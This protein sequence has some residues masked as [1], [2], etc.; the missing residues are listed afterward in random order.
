M[1]QENDVL[2]LMKKMVE[3]RK[4]SELATTE[5]LCDMVYQCIEDNVPIR[6]QW[7]LAPDVIVIREARL[8]YPPPVITETVEMNKFY[9]ACMNEEQTALASE[10]LFQLQVGNSTILKED[11]CEWLH[12]CNSGIGPV[13][14]NTSPKD[15]F[16]NLNFPTEWLKKTVELV[17]NTYSPTAVL[18]TSEE[19]GVM[20]LD[21]VM[22]NLA[23]FGNKVKSEE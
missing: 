7:Q 17:A 1:D 2:D 11:L 13:A 8:V 23:S 20:R 18:G 14:C 4:I 5:R 15:S 21:A 22:E 16:Y 9:T 3:K 12:Q 6:A 10:M 19:T